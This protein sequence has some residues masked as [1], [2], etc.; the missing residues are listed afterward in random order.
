MKL[1]LYQFRCYG[2][3]T[4][5]VAHHIVFQWYASIFGCKHDVKLPSWK[6]VYSVRE[7][8]RKGEVHI[9]CIMG[10]ILQT[11]LVIFRP[12]LDVIVL[13]GIQ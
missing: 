4:S 5:S 6:Y 13:P 10:G 7:T 12:V 1:S 2:E 11:W 9:T 8:G 3:S